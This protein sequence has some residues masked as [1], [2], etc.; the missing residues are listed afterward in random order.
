M[1]ANLFVG[2]SGGKHSKT[3]VLTNTIVFGGL[4]NKRYYF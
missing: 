4:I 1:E 3:T 2:V